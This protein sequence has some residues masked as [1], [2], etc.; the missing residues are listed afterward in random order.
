VNG[1]CRPPQESRQITAGQNL[2]TGRTVLVVAVRKDLFA[3]TAGRAEQ[4]NLHLA[5]IGIKF[6][7]HLEFETAAFKAG[8]RLY[9]TYYLRSILYPD[10]LEA[11]PD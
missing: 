3:L 6:T 7:D 5:R 1:S 10:F 4:E 8:L 2:E 9:S 11:L